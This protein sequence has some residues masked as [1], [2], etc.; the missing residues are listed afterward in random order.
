M[1]QNAPHGSA[2]IKVFVILAAASMAGCVTNASFNVADKYVT[3]RQVDS[4]LIPDAETIRAMSDIEAMDFGINVERCYLPGSTRPGSI[5]E[6]VG[7]IRSSEKQNIEAEKLERDVAASMAAKQFHACSQSNEYRL[8]LA[9]SSIVSLRFELNELSKMKD[10]QRAYVNES[11]VRNLDLE[12]AIGVRAVNARDR[13][14]SEYQTYIELGGKTKDPIK[15][16]A[17]GNPC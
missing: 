2:T 17:R 4:L 7:Q 6:R 12:R 5:M 16:K 3:C 15:I 1:G 9:E 14:W 11:G 13:L 8:Y 10:Q